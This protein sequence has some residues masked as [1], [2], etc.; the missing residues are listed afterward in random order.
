MDWLESLTSL[1]AHHCEQVAAVCLCCLA[2]E[3][4]LVTLSKFHYTVDLL[5]SLLLVALFWDSRA[6]DSIAGDWTEGYKWG[7]PSWPD[8]VGFSWARLC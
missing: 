6:A 2:T 3:F 5:A 7:S 4:V 1:A 8:L